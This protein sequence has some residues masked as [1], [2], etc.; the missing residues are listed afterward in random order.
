MKEKNNDHD[1]KSEKFKKY[2]G[3]GL[4][5]FATI[6]IWFGFSEILYLSIDHIQEKR[7]RY[8]YTLVMTI[9][10]LSIVLFINW[11]RPS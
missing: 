11:N 9:L 1:K 6:V 10:G 5:L 8:I 3:D 7:K 2:L 4:E